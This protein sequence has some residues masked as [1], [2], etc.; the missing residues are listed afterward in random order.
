MNTVTVPKNTYNYLVK[1]NQEM[2]KRISFIEMLVNDMAR[3][4]I[5]PKYQ[6]K[7]NKISR[8]M[9]NGK[10]ISFRNTSQVK[11]FFRNL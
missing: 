5:T 1:S 6:T 8:S 2:G 9:G 4:E 3:D 11:K 7:L 10:G